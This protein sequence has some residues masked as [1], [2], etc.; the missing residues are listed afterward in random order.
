VTRLNCELGS[1]SVKRSI[2]G[3]EQRHAYLQKWLAGKAEVFCLGGVSRPQGLLRALASSKTGIYLHLADS[4]AL[5][6]LF[7]VFII[8]FKNTSFTN[9]S[10]SG[11]YTD[12]SK[13]S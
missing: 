11:S 2:I 4:N 8:D 7:E 5:G 10:T 6:P 12:W 9:F 3:L 1:C 13:F